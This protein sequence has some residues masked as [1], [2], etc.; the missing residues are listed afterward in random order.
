MIVNG[1]NFPE[2]RIGDFCRR[3]G[4]ARLSIFGSIL[5]EPSDEHGYSFRP[6]SDVDMLIEFLPGGTPGLLALSSMQLELSAMIGRHVD[7]R[8]PR[9]LSRYFREEVIREARPLHAA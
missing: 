6:S 5:R 1:V 4:V 2:D 7:L 9:E 8:T 3:H